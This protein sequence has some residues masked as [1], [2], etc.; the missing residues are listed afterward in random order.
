MP[1][2]KQHEKDVG[3]HERWEGQMHFYLCLHHAGDGESTP[4]TEASSEEKQ[5]DSLAE[6]PP[7]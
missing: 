1:V 5:W 2:W 6:G 4:S 3:L 7:A